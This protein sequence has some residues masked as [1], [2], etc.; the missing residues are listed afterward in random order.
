M[1]MLLM[2]VAYAISFCNENQKT[3]RNH[4]P[5]KIIL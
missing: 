4:L 3:F 2:N 1:M 5:Y